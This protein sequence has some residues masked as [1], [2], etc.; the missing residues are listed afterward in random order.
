MRV[1][2]AKADDRPVM[3]ASEVMPGIGI[4]NAPDGAANML[5]QHHDVMTIPSDGNCSR[6]RRRTRKLEPCR[7]P[8]ERPDRRTKYLDRSATSAELH[9]GTT[10]RVGYNLSSSRH[11]K[12]AE[13][14][15]HNDEPTQL[16]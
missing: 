10:G 4:I 2:D 3:D 14:K 5:E 6:R 8:P 13:R 12:P 9:R 7:C 16:S 15:Q 1:H 11:I